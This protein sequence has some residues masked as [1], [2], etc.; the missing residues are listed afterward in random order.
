MSAPDN[1]SF[2]GEFLS[3]DGVEF[4]VHEGAVVAESDGEGFGEFDRF[5]VLEANGA[6]AVETEDL[7]QV[8]EAV[9]RVEAGASTIT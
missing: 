4:A 7:I 1:C 3:V 6:L 2:H 9:T 8:D 5:T